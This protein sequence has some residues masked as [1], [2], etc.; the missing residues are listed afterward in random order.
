[1]T[2]F[3]LSGT[4]RTTLNLDRPNLTLE[5]W[6]QGEW[7]IAKTTESALLHAPDIGPL[8]A[9]FPGSV[10]GALVDADVVPDSLIGVQ[11]RASEFLEQRHWIYPTTLPTD[12]D[13]GAVRF[14]ADGV[15]GRAELVSN[16]AGRIARAVVIPNTTTYNAAIRVEVAVDNARAG[17]VEVVVV[18]PDDTEVALAVLALDASG[19]VQA[20]VDI[21]DAWRWAPTG[22]GFTAGGKP[23][24]YTVHIRLLDED[25]AELDRI[26]RRAGFRRVDWQSAPGTS[27]GA[28]PWNLH[29]DR[30]R[31]FLQGVNWVPIRPDFA[32]VADSEFRVGLETY[33]RLGVNL[34]RIWGGATTEC[35]VVYETCDEL[36]LLVWQ[37]LPLSATGL[38]NRPPDDDEYVASLAVIATDWAQRL[39]H[40][41]SVVIWSGGNELAEGRPMPGAPL[42][43]EPPALAAARDAVRA[44]SPSV[45]VV[46]TTPSGPRYLATEAEFGLG[47]H[48]DV[49]GPWGHASSREARIRY[50]Q[51]DDALMRSEVGIA[52]A[53]T[54]DV[55]ER[56]GLNGH[57]TE[58]T[59][60]WRHS[61]AWWVDKEAVPPADEL[62]DWVTAS[63]A[64]QADLLA[65]AAAAT[66][67]RYP[68]CGGFLVWMGHDSFP[69]AVSLA[70]LDVDGR[71][72]TPS[73][74]A[75]ARV[76]TTGSRPELER[77]AGSVDR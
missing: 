23:N 32:D 28:L 13:D 27:V 74:S 40:H 5:G 50:W 47:L 11:S 31:R 77:I 24:L 37:D 1:M 64:R 56:F 60:S 9:R 70:I 44:V 62:A 20:D 21:P 73:A 59:E 53:S 15:A 63:Q 49:H 6:R 35:D 54:V 41:P 75:L 3:D 46:P 76:L 42:G 57:T 29:V 26:S 55:L 67:S 52:G 22:D 8:P 16:A 68:S 25:G 48:H 72:T 33:A 66:K 18:S 4:M 10:R 71:P 19:W 39:A 38:N 12:L 14:N 36:G 43:F 45:H 30:S 69:C 7:E 17:R 51:S 2:K 58:L 65:I 61:S 34:V